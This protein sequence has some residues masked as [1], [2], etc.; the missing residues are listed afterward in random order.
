M[1]NLH[2]LECTLKGYDHI[3]DLL[4]AK[5]WVITGCKFAS[6]SSLKSVTIGNSVTS[7]G[8]YAFYNC[9]SLKS[10]TIPN[11]V[12]EIGN[13][14][15]S[16]CSSLTSVT[17]PESVTEIGNNAFYNCSSLTSVIIPESVTWIGDS[18]FG[19]CESLTS[20][21]CKRTTPPLSGSKPFKYT[22][23]ELKIYVPT[24]SVEAYKSAWSEYEAKIEGYDF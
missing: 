9:S 23:S 20:V 10:V 12:T 6:C 7:I 18:A 13:N 4:L 22:A 1:L 2:L 21:Y 14:A 15:F 17:I 3:S 19:Y 24:A 5:Y 16:N 11:G 8:S